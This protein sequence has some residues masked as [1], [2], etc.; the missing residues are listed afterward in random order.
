MQDYIPQYITLWNLRFPR[1][2][3]FKVVF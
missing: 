1:R 2:W 3:E